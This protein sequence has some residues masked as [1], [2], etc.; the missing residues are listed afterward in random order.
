MFASRVYDVCSCLVCEGTCLRS[1]L[2]G[3]GLPRTLCIPAPGHRP[4]SVIHTTL[5]RGCPYRSSSR[6][7]RVGPQPRHSRQGHHRQCSN[8]RVGLS[9]SIQGIGERLGVSHIDCDL[10][11]LLVSLIGLFDKAQD[12][13]AVEDM[14]DAHRVIGFSGR[15][16]SQREVSPFPLVSGRCLPMVSLPLVLGKIGAGFCICICY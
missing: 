7:G 9:P 10:L 1:R 8:K 6:A 14:A 16:R 5:Q 13:H 2:M 12:Y 4:G 3:I 15:R 11:E